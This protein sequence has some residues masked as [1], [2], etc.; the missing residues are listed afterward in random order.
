SAR[1]RRP[2]RRPKGPAAGALERAHRLEH[3]DAPAG[4]EVDR[5]PARVAP[6]RLER[7]QVS[8][9][10]V[11]DVDVVADPG[12]VPGGIVAS[13]YPHPVA[14]AHGDLSDIR[15]EVVGNAL[16]VLP[17]QPA[18]VG[19]DRIEVAQQLAPTGERVRRPGDP[20]AP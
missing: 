6:Q 11:D 12:A 20:T 8:A 10:Q 14:N 13:E 9:R 3:R 17:Y 7:R 5:E 2:P 18:R 19:S 4:A 15:H 16:R 1:A